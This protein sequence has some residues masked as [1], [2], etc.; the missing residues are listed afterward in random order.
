VLLGYLILIAAPAQHY[1]CPPRRVARYADSAKRV[2]TCNRLVRKGLKR[3]FDPFVI[4]EL[5]WGESH[6][7]SDALHPR[8]K[9]A[10]ALQAQPRYWCPDGKRKGC[11]LEAAGLRAWAYYK[12]KQPTLLLA[13]CHY[14]H[15][16]AKGMGYARM[17]L[18][19]IL[20][21]RWKHYSR[22]KK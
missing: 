21:S 10:G 8:S 11:D 19:R 22:R 16:T 4:A 12:K 3:G 20:R 15:C 5:A 1:A 2:A 6:W 17:T 14:K 7:D 18:S 13:L 9:C